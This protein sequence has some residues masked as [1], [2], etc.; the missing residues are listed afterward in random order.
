VRLAENERVEL[1]SG[2][3]GPAERIAPGSGLAWTRGLIVLDAAPLSEVIAEL[4]HMAPG[5][6]MIADSR[7][8]ALTLSGVFQADD[9][10]AVI[11]AMKSGLGLRAISV[12]GLATLIYR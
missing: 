9:P 2:R 5:R 6:V 7:L 1:I 8:N 4:A 3:L 11:E 12:P 10:D